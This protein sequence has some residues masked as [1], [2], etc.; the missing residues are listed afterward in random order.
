M[1]H[2]LLGTPS[3]PSWDRQRVK[4]VLVYR[5]QPITKPEANRNI[6]AAILLQLI[7]I[8]ETPLY[9][10]LCWPYLDYLRVECGCCID[11]GPFDS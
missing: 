8:Y 10:L 6:F 4:N 2:D 1:N 9:R 3:L 5:G 7:I 11:I